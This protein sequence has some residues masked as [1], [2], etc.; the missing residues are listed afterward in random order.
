MRVKQPL[1]LRVEFSFPLENAQHVIGK[2]I[3]PLKR[4]MWKCSHG[5]YSIALLVVTEES[6]LELVKRLGLSDI[7]GIEDYTCHVAPIGA[8]CMHGGMNTLH[9]AL[10]KAWDAVGQ[11]RNPEYMRQTKRFDPRLERRVD[12]RES[13]AIRQVKIEPSSVRQPPKN[14]DR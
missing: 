9:T 1:L 14:P 6:A 10:T 2:I 13:G 8:I 3:G 7:S 12:D 4:Q 5:K 11:R